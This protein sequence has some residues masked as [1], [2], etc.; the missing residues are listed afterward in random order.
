MKKNEPRDLTPEEI[1]D[2][3][4]HKA[5]VGRVARA[6]FEK[7]KASTGIVKLSAQP[8]QL[9]RPFKPDFR[10]LMEQFFNRQSPAT[11]AAYKQGLQ[12]FAGWLAVFVGDAG[13][14]PENAAKYLITCSAPEANALVMNYVGWLQGMPSTAEDGGGIPHRASKLAPATVNQRLAALNSLVKLG[15]L[16]GFC[17]WKLTVPGL[18]V[19]AQR[20]VRG[21]SG[22]DLKAVRDAAKKLGREHAAIVAL[23]FERGLRSIE[24]RELKLEHLKLNAK[25]PHIMVRGKGRTGL[26]PLT[27]AESTAKAVAD[28]LEERGQQEVVERGDFSIFAEAPAAQPDGFVFCAPG[29]FHRGLSRFQLWDRVRKVGASVDRK[30]WPHAL[31]HS[32]L[33]ALL[34][35]TNGDVRSVQKFSR[36]K[37][38]DTLLKYDDA[39]RDVAGELARKLGDE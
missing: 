12:E 18:K 30:L 13:V 25:P 16:L 1:H 36:H 38:I 34:D 7:R 22:D 29:E 31:R 14:T 39:R 15:N 6:H 9:A 35:K 27:I 4:E 20:D 26:E 28:W 2:L 23:L 33:T 17:S 5:H 8:A 21:P 32:S 37:H 11:I 10:R 3:R 24:V 19:Q